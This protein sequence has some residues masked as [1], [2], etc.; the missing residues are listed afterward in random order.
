MEGTVVKGMS[1]GDCGEKNEGRGSMG[2]A[3]E[4]NSIDKGKRL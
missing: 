2:N 3:W 1:G 4:H